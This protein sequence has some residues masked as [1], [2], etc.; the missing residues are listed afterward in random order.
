MRTLV[1][2]GTIREVEQ[3]VSQMKKDGWTPITSVKLDDS[4]IMYNKIYYICVLERPTIEGG[5][6]RWNRRW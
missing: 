3:R 2:A 4:E 1:R 5:P 6:K